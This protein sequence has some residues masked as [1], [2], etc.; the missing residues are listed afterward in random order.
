M[1]NSEWLRNL[2]DE[3]LAELVDLC[4]LVREQECP[5]ATYGLGISCAQCKLNWLQQNHRE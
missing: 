1:T 3:E 4:E 5:N 2:N